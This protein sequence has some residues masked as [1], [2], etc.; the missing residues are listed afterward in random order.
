MK[1]QLNTCRIISIEPF[2]EGY[3]RRFKP[4]GTYTP[5]LG[6]NEVVVGV[7]SG[8]NYLFVHRAGVLYSV[9]HDDFSFDY[10]TQ[11]LALLDSRLTSISIP[12]SYTGSVPDDDG[13]A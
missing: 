12:G 1:R 6:Q 10:I 7:Y 3:S 9:S 11:E 5:A 2:A 4:T 8:S 13:V